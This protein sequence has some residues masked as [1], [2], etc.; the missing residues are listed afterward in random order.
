MLLH[1]Y[2]KLQCTLQIQPPTHTRP[3]LIP[4]LC[5]HFSTSD[6]SLSNIVHN[7]N[8]SLRLFSYSML[9]IRKHKKIQETGNAQI[10]RDNN[11]MINSNEQQFLHSFKQSQ[12]IARPLMLVSPR[13]AYS[14]E[15]STNPDNRISPS[16]PVTKYFYPFLINSSSTV[17]FPHDILLQHILLSFYFSFSSKLNLRKIHVEKS[18]KFQTYIMWEKLLEDGRKTKCCF[19]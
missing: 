2:V 6:Y 13:L 8:I 1:N 7:N 12:W 19:S 4:F 3:Q 17:P 11:M 16:S 14:F 9:R 15:S 10:R 18:Y 5:F